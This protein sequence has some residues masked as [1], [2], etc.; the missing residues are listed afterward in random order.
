MTLNYEQ[1]LRIAAQK[2]KQARI[3]QNL[4]IEDLARLTGI[5]AY[6]IKKIETGNYNFYLKDFDKIQNI[7]E[8]DIKLQKRR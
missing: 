5:S 3:E 2:I 1:S 6:K 4:S 8:L 7:L